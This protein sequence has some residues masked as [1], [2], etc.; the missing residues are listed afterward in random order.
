MRIGLQV[1]DFK[2]PGGDAAIGPTFADIARRAEDAGFYSVWVMDHFYQIGFIGPAHDPML[3]AYSA[4]SFAAGVTSRVKLGAMV[5]GVTY[6]YP[7]I[8]VKQVTTLDVLSRGRAY[9]GI[10]AAWNEQEHH[11]MGAPFPAIRER[12]ERLEET[13]QIAHQMWS[14]EAKPFAGKHYQLPE[15]ICR[16]LPLSK[17]HPTILIG[18][19]GEK[20]TLRLVA[21]Y[22][23][24]CNL[25]PTPEL[26]RKLDVLKEH[27]AAEGRPY[28]E[29]EKTVLLNLNVNQPAKDGGDVVKRAIDQLGEYAN[30]G[31]DQVMLALPTV[32]DPHAFDLFGERLVPDASGITVA[33]R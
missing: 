19:G 33:G 1:N 7:G 12:F 4:L 23:D 6:R 15:P 25:F 22:G 31:I 21:K 28:E 29:I 10:G 32:S 27:C 2:W 9:L 8:L 30:L 20:K 18:G 17:P 14:G 11:D 24:A 5:T 13:L 16:P 26:P 3:E